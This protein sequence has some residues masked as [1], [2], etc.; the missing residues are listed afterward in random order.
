MQHYTVPFHNNK[1]DNLTHF[2]NP[3]LLGKAQ[4]VWL[5]RLQLD[6]GH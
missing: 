1:L 6:E 5:W 4:L 3:H 2:T